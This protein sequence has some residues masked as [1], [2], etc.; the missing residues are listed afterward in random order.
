MIGYLQGRAVS[1]DT[2]R[3][4]GTGVGYR[5]TTLTVMTV[6]ET[7][8]LWVHTQTTDTATTLYGF[9]STLQR[10]LFTALLK[11]PGVGGRTACDIIASDTL[12]VVT[13]HLRAQNITWVTSIKGLGK[14]T[15][16]KLFAHLKLPTG[17]PEETGSGTGTGVVTI[18]D[19]VV[20]AVV[21]LTGADPAQA[22]VIVTQLRAEGITDESVLVPAALRVHNQGALL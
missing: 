16:T 3:A 19:D 13:A 10:D 15:G 12:P 2:L 11:C 18:A 7:Y 22:A 8:R 21:D 17:L 9:D 5:V 20:A 14:A 1:G 6:D 4:H